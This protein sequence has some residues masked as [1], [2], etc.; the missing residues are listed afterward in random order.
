M[1]LPKDKRIAVKKTLSRYQLF[2]GRIDERWTPGTERALRRGAEEI[3]YRSS[4][5]SRPRLNNE[6]NTAIYIEKLQNGDFGDYFQKE[7]HAQL[8]SF[9][10]MFNDG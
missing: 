10:S 7:A 1:S 3:A 8:W 6:A 2:V 5:Y 4:S 9:L